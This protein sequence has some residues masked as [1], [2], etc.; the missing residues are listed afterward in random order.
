MRSALQIHMPGNEAFKADPQPSAPGGE[1]T[2]CLDSVP[3]TRVYRLCF[4]P[5]CVAV[6]A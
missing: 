5:Y 1:Q 3:P 2:S 6:V 4:S